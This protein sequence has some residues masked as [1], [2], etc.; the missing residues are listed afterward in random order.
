M[1]TVSVDPEIVSQAANKILRKSQ[2]TLEKLGD[3]GN[4]AFLNLK[5]NVDLVKKVTC[6]WYQ[7]PTDTGTILNFSSCDPLLNKRNVI[8]GALHRVLRSTST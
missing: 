7:K 5:L 8:D 1:R 2:F 6:G 4:L 3:E